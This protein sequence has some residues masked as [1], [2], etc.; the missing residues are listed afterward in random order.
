VS[1]N[2]ACVGLPVDDERDSAAWWNKPA[3]LAGRPG[4]SMA[5]GSCAAARLRPR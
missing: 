2:L 3:P 5:S 1:P 4:H